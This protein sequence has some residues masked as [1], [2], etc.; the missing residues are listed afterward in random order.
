MWARTC[1]FPEAMHFDVD[2]SIVY[3]RTIV[4]A[5]MARDDRY[6]R[7]TTRTCRSRERRMNGDEDLLCAGHDCEGPFADIRPPAL[8][9]DRERDARAIEDVEFRF[10]ELQRSRVGGWTRNEMGCAASISQETER[11]FRVH[12][13]VMRGAGM[14][15]S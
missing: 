10:H 5:S 11:V 1:I 6:G 12:D 9:V 7:D 15:Q 8:P 3:V 13:E 2:L 14:E 4:G